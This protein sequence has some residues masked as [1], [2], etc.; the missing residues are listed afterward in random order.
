[1]PNS[2]KKAPRVNYKVIVVAVLLIA[3]LVTTGLMGSFY[4]KY[5]HKANTGANV[6][7]GDF[8]FQSDYLT[9]AA[10]VPT[11]HI[12]GSSVAIKLQNHDGLNYTDSEIKY[13]LALSDT[14]NFSST[15]TGDQ[16]LAGGQ[17]STTTLTLT[18]QNDTV[19]TVTVTATASAPYAKTIKAIFEFHAPTTTAYSI[20]DN[21]T[22]VEVNLYTGGTL[23]AGGIT[24]TYPTDT[25]V[26]DRTNDLIAGNTTGSITLTGLTAQAQ[27]T[28]IFFKY[29][30]EAIA[31]TPQ[32]TTELP[33][34]NTIAIT[35]STTP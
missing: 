34:N 2:K 27:Y 15:V 3:V 25:L 14:T 35:R 9:D 8:K 7:S 29:D 18:S 24:I 33:A 20:A 21:G 17:Q 1:M 28:F 30:A 11:Y 32:T 31:Y 22:H 5:V 23:P 4:A 16:T 19:K 13:S 26:P 6:T 12:Y 10:T